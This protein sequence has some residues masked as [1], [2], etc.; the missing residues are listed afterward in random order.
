MVENIPKQQT[1]KTLLKTLPVL[2]S[3]TGIWSK[4]LQFLEL[5]SINRI[6]IVESIIDRVK[7]KEGDHS[8]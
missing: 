8:K 1:E 5:L 7:Y 2:P 4:K 3:S 6:R